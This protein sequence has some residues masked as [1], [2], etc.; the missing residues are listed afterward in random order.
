MSQQPRDDPAALTAEYSQLLSLAAHEFRTPASVVC[1]YLR[2]L[3]RDT[4]PLSDRQRKMVD[5][6]AKSCARLVG[7][8]T[9]LSEIGKLDSNAAAMKLETVDLFEQL[10]EVASS[11]HEG[12]DRE[13]QLQLSG[14]ETGAQVTGDAARLRAAFSAI[15]HA[16]LREQPQGSVVAVERRLE[17]LGDET[18]AVVIVARETDVQRAYEA[19]PLVFDEKRGGLGLTLPIARR[20]IERQGGRVWS[21]EPAH[22]ED[23]AL[24]SAVVV[25][26][27]LRS[28]AVEETVHFDRR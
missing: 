7:L 16:I 8:I 22:A 9:E 24:K 6:A 18:S 25:S 19:T 5:E 26:L 15:L 4:D 3:Q 27:P 12:E 2:M 17:Y 23:R 11:V 21:P 20:V 10:A 14:M 28:K 1:G 13:V